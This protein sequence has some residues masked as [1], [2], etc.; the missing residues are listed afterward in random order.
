MTAGAEIENAV[1]RLDS[2]P[3]L[4][5]GLYPTP[6]E[7]LTRLRAELGENCPRIFIKRDDYTGFGFGGNKIRKLEFLFPKIL[8]EG[9][10]VVITTG[11]ERSNHARMTAA[12]CAKL[13]LRCVLVLD[14]KPRPIGAQ[15]LRPA[16]NYVEELYGAEVH[17]VDSIEERK[18]V[19]AKLAREI[20]NEGKKIYEIPLGGAVNVGSLGFVLAMREIAAQASDLGVQFDTIVFSSS[21]A[22]THAGMLIGAKLFGL[23][24][25]RFLGMSPEPDAIEEITAEVMRLLREAGGLL[26]IS[27]D[28]LI[29]KIEI[30]DEYA[31]DGYC[32][33][34]SEADTALKLL[35]RTEA[36]I[37]D[38]VYT[39][40]AMAGMLDLIEK[41]LLRKDS[42]VLF[43]H[44]GGQTT[45]FY[46]PEIAT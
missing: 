42:N 40:K 12:V 26:Q 1:N 30:N 11:G 2:F 45:L 10:D 13:G 38:P 27:T 3:Y 41:R 44:T 36:V 5:L 33:E 31:G 6:L 35:A 22:G 43:W 37:L 29:D 28:E 24:T 19:A 23:E 8:A 34:T 4:K 14:H 9:A 15:K 18:R 21:T 39:G 20:A 25:S 17:L 46:T 16:A 32:V 7:E